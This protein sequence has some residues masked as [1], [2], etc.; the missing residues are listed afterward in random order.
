MSAAP[1]ESAFKYK[2]RDWTIVALICWNIQHAALS[3]AA[4]A[5]GWVQVAY[6]TIAV[7]SLIWLLVC[8]SFALINWVRS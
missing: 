6:M 7:A 8:L 5:T 3:D 2:A 4:K 1:T